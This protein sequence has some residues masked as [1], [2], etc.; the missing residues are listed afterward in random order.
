MQAPSVALAFVFTLVM[1]G[2]SRTVRAADEV[3]DDPE[4][5]ART[6]EK[7]RR[8][9]PRKKPKEKRPK[10][11]SPTD[12]TLEEEEDKPEGEAG[13]SGESLGAT[14]GEQVIADP[15][16]AEETKSD[17][18]FGD[19]N[20]PR[21]ARWGVSL[22]TRWGYDTQQNQR[23]PY[24]DDQGQQA[25]QGRNQQDIVEGTTV[26]VIEVEQRR[27]DELFL[28]LGVRVRHAVAQP[29]RGAPG[30]DLD[31]APLSAFADLTPTPGF[32][33]RAGYQVTTMGR[34]DVFTATNYL[35]VLDLRSGPVTMPEAANI[36]QP[37]VRIDIDAISGLTIQAYYIPFFT[38]HLYPVYGGNYA[39]LD[40][41]AAVTNNL[42]EV[43]SLLDNFT[44]RS[45]LS[46]ASTNFAQAFA[47]APDFLKPQG[48]LRMNW[49]G[50]AGELAITAGTALDHLPSEFKFIPSNDPAALPLSVEVNHNRFYTAAVDGSLDVGPFQV[51]AELSYT[52]QRTLS[53]VGTLAPAAGATTPDYPLV[54][55]KANL[56][57]A[58]LR[59][60]LVEHAGWNAAVEAF[61]QAALS[62]PSRSAPEGREWDRY[63]RWI[64][65]ENGRLTR[66]IA[67]GVQFA[68][69]DTGLKFELGAVAYTGPSYVL[70]PRIEW[71]AL[72]R[73]YIEVGGVF[74]AGPTPG[75]LGSPNVSLAGLYSDIDQ[76]FLGIKWV[77]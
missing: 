74:V 37:A 63:P 75:G 56:V 66:G 9:P 73:F 12:V 42:G 59:A 62:D 69:E 28:S 22:H 34:F 54:S 76:V 61:V 15:E 32:H 2:L 13:G 18:S 11:P 25:F 71:E 52:A 47:P 51:G 21:E 8:L 44:I 68:P 23:F 31:I 49:S 30:Y 72:T 14:D 58:G 53:G 35:A 26:A 38:P 67:G 33:V 36:A 29:K 77:P 24:I 7:P 41:F 45:K 43:R 65:M 48:A 16:L 3:I 60:E 57:Q 5:S 17:G 20:G 27:S 46:R 10:T 4:L 50:S 1:L 64:G 40:R 19:M 39:P 70:T 6:G 55:G